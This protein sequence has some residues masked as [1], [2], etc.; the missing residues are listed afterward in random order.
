MISNLPYRA[1][2]HYHYEEEKFKRNVVRIWIVDERKYDY[3]NGAEVK[4]IHSFYDTK[5]QKFY[6]PVNSKTIGK[7]VDIDLTT[8]YSS[9]I[10]KRSPLDQF[11]I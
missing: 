9:M 8:P 6:S 4:C 7:E 10:I 1:P 3:N 11:F 5:K 2:K